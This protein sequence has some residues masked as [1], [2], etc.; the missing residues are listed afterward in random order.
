MVER[1]KGVWGCFSDFCFSMFCPCLARSSSML[2]MDLQW[3]SQRG[4]WGAAAQGGERE[5]IWVYVLSL[6]IFIIKAAMPLQCFGTVHSVC[7]H[8]TSTV[9]ATM[10]WFRLFF[11][12]FCAFCFFVFSFFFIYNAFGLVNQHC[13]YSP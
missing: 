12:F 8:C 11:F 6:Y 13:I 3:L 5:K 7:L 1:S 4:F 9:A 10:L 2:G